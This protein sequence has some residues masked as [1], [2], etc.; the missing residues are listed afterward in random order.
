M[1]KK[2][3]DILIQKFKEVNIQVDKIEILDRK[4]RI[5]RT[6]GMFIIK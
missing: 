3:N 4:K 1:R 6:F 2:L 5:K